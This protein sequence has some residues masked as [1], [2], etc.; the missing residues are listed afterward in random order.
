MKALILNSGMGKRMGNITADYPKC[1]TEIGENESILSRQLKQ[2]YKFGIEEV[3]ITTGYF[4]EVLTRY[5]GE[6]NIPLKIEFV[7]N[8]LYDKTNYIY[9]I[10]LAK[11]RLKADI[12]LLHGDLVFDDHVLE[13][14]IKW[15]ISCM[16]VSSAVPLPEKDFKAVLD[17]GRITKIGIE[18]FDN[19]V[20][21][22]PLYKF[23]YSDFQ[24]WLSNIIKFCEDGDTSCYAENA[25][26]EILGDV[27]L[28]PYDVENMLCGEIDTIEDLAIM[29]KILK[30]ND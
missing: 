8:P 6:L 1:M 27:L 25:L 28:K 7:N 21:A 16:T 2:L 23:L 5:V 11:D 24:N 30:G 20:S 17:E 3:V 14:I 29:K 18:F 4:N 22:Q 15:E 19:A 9:S 12:L 13:K 10:Y 26:N